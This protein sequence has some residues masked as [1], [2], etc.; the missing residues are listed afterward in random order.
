MHESIYFPEDI[1]PEIVALIRRGSI[2]EK[3]R[4]IKEQLEK[5]C[6]KLE[7]YWNNEGL[8]IDKLNIDDMMI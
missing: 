5:Q 7:E 6:K 8:K 2:D 4:E 3:D 1:I